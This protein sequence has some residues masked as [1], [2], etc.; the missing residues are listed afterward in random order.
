MTPTHRNLL[1]SALNSPVPTS[2]WRDR[3]LYA[4]IIIGLAVLGTWAVWEWGWV[5][6][7]VVRMV[8]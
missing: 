6:D 5:L 8:P 4:L 1:L 3:W 7:G 2:L